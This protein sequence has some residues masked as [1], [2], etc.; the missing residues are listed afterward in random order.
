M[1]FHPISG[2]EIP[3]PDGRLP[4]YRYINPRPAQWPESEYIVGNPPFIGG[5]DIRAELGDGYTEALWASRGK[6]SD[7]IDLV[8][9]WWDQAASYLTRKATKLRRFGFIT[10]NSITQKFSRRVVEKHITADKPLSIVF[11]VPDHPWQKAARKAAVRIA[12]TVAEKGTR[13][14]R[15]AEVAEEQ[16]LDTD[17]PKVLLVER[18]GNINADITIGADLTSAR[19]LK[20]NDAISSR[21]VQLHGDGFIVDAQQAVALGL[22]RVAGVDKLIKPYLHNRDLKGR[23]RGVWV[24][25]AFGFSESELRQGFPQI[26]QHLQEKVRA[27]RQNQFDESPTKDAKEYLQRWWTF[28]KSREE[29][30]TAISGL[31]R[32]IVT[33]ETSKHRF[34]EF[35]PV[36]T[37]ADNMIRVIASDDPYF[38]GVLT[39]R[40]HTVFSL[41]KGGWLGV[42]ND[43]RYQADCFV[44][45]PFP[46]AADAEKKRIGTLSEEL[47]LLRKKVL[48]DHDFLTITKL[49][50]V[51]EK[52]ISGEPLNESEQAVHEV[53][54]VGVIHELHNQIDRAVAEAYGWPSDLSDEEILTRVVALNKERAEEEKRAHIRW[55]RPEYQIA[56]T[57]IR[58]AKEEQIEAALEAPEAAAPNLPKDDAE[59]VATLRQT[60]R[61]IGRPVEAKDI[62]QRFR[63]GSRGAR[64]VERGLNL[65]AAAG[66]VRRTKE[67]W[68]LPSDRA[69]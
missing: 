60:L 51:R 37:I 34:F 11:A 32:L 57:K 64:R 26:W 50:N 68:F 66:V 5:K 29:I 45:F 47:D 1:K 61:V 49:Y 6:K 16:D 8:M 44:A 21:G 2:E 20:A 3:D 28:G 52:L 69:A 19:P 36:N 39:S 55:L 23:P 9:Y 54:C 53:G 62:A 27:A 43:P 17:Q 12:M 13:I 7:S 56:R 31:T 48:A 24:I 15:L 33:G 18:I 22:G 30:R 35:F 59:L 41:R 58:V 38:L 25:D 10:T 42:G 14:G 67:G 4:V 65:L 46:D 63:E 40:A